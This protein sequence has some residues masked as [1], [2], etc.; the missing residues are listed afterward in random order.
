MMDKGAVHD[1]LIP[2]AAEALLSPGPIH[3]AVTG[4]KCATAEHSFE[5]YKGL[6]MVWRRHSV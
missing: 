2:Q 6:V 4:A 3:P 1:N 5:F